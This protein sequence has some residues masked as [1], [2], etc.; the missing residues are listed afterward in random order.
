MSDF[1]NTKKWQKNKNRQVSFFVKC[2]LITQV[3]VQDVV[4]GPV[5][6][7]TDLKRPR[8]QMNLS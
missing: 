4:D 8:R 5:L 7:Y 2:S 3:Q 6:P 1:S